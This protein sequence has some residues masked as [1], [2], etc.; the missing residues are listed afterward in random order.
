MHSSGLVFVDSKRLFYP[1][2]ETQQQFL[3]EFYQF[4]DIDQLESSIQIRFYSEIIR[5]LIDFLGDYMN[6]KEYRKPEWV[7]RME[8]IQKRLAGKLI[9]FLRAFEMGCSC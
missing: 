2:Y 7:T 9:V 1:W 5:Y 6:S 8:E 4:L 3:I